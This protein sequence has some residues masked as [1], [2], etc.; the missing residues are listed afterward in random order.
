MGTPSTPYHKEQEKLT[1]R[2]KVYGLENVIFDTR[3]V[4][5]SDDLRL[6]YVDEYAKTFDLSASEKDQMLNEQIEQAQ[7]FDDFYIAHFAS[8]R[9]FQRIHEQ[10]EDKKMWVLRLEDAGS[11]LRPI[12]IDPLK[13]TNHQEYF[14]PIMDEFS[15]LYKVRFRKSTDPVKVLSMNSPARSIKFE[16]K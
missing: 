6:K 3:V 11:E 2:K 14:F 10:V 13:R 1:K 8:E 15:K 7:Q 16:W 5:F 9:G 4:Y 12:A